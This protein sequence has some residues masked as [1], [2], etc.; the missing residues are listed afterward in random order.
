MPL[1]AAAHSSPSGALEA[2]ERLRR[3]LGERR[4]F[5]I[6]SHMNPDPDTVGSALGLR[7]LLEQVFERKAAL[8]YRGII[9]RAENREL[10]RLL[11]KDLKPARMV[12]QEQYEA[13]FLVDCQ[14]DFGFDS[15]VDR[16]P[17][18]GVF[19]HHPDS[20]SAAG[21]PFSDIRSAY[22]S[23][24]TI[25]TE[26]IRASGME[27]GAVVATAL[28]Y[29]LKTD[30]QDLSR[31]TGAADED[32]RDWLVPRID[33][34]TLA[35][36]E[37]PKLSRSYYTNLMTA[38]ARAVSWRELVMTEIGRLPYPDMV[39]EIA[40]RLIRMEQVQWSMCCGLHEKRLYL[41]V[42]TS[43]P[44]LDAGLLVKRVL[45][46]RGAG[47]G[48]DTM[49]AGRIELA[50][51]GRETYRVAVEDLWSRFREEL[52]LHSVEGVRVVEHAPEGPRVGGAWSA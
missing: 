29:G 35:A 9:G 50:D 36:I 28:W 21:L 20:G 18:L 40:D 46:G 30:T 12:P 7:F 45:R 48:H 16:V 31:R 47:G 34:A 49:A 43:H 32:A 26:Y 14:P 44:T 2:L 1:M 52:G 15:E 13:S 4:A 10:V 25:I 33:R 41:S 42:R 51:E 37:N 22:G 3:A 19:D 8:C 17:L 38:L 6:Y 23:T 39:A 24:S 11:A 5:L 27:P